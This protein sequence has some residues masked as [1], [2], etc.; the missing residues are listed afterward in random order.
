[1][2]LPAL[3]K[4]SGMTLATTAAV[5][6][7]GFATSVITARM[8]GP[9]G[10]GLLSA[11]VLIA[12]LSGS[13]ALCGLPNSFVYHRGAGRH[14]PYKALLV[15]S[16]LLICTF[17]VLLALAGVRLANS[18]R[19]RSE[20]GL[21]L[22]LAAATA[23]QSYFYIVSQLHHGLK[24]FNGM[25]IGLVVGNLS[26]LLVVAALFSPLGYEQVLLAQTVVMSALAVTGV[27]W[28]R[29]H[30]I[31]D[32]RPQD[33]SAARWRDIWRYGVSHHGTVL[34]GLLLANFDKVALLRIGSMAEF[35]IYALAFTTSRLIGAVQDAA[36]TALYARFAGKDTAELKQSVNRAFRITFLPMLT[37]AT[38]GALCSPWLMAGIYGPAFRS[39]ALPFSI[40]LFECVIGQASWTLAQRFNAS[41][42][43]GLVFLRQ[44]ISLIP[45][46]FLLPF[47]PRED[48]P[49]YLAWLMLIGAV[50]RLVVTMSLYPLSLKE[51][52]PRV[53]PRRAD[54][55]L[56]MR[57]FA[58]ARSG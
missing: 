50:L 51:R 32:S 49:A 16:L 57:R 5:T 18:V 53:F 38:A 9:E 24:F 36:S 13:I 45:V 1:M 41:G 33:A 27:A 2:A 3:L 8:L 10:R 54:I 37:V 22:S 34:L 23:V 29:R 56:V 17:A 19:L 47:V 39:M 11:A 58:T 42:R 7:L 12:T 21:I 31:W 35:G 14:F 46:L 28:A 40:L 43:P 20:V 52:M 15:F 25:R 55:E 26:A 48:T 44:F 30:V 6:L 4:A